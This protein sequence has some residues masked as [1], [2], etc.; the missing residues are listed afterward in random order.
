M[1]CSN[2]VMCS[3]I[4]SSFHQSK[5]WSK[6]KMSNKY[7]SGS[8]IRTHNS[9]IRPFTYL[10][11]A[12]KRALQFSTK[13]IKFCCMKKCKYNFQIKNSRISLHIFRHD[14]P[15]LSATLKIKNHFVTLRS[16]YQ[17]DLLLFS[18]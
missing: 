7:R 12:W 2:S 3:D 17:V 4:L 13:E 8:R 1:S 18:R 15:L 10:G 6:K 14:C 11:S 9:R 16:W 5:L